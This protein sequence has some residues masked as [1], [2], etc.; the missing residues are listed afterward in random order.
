MTFARHWF[1][2]LDA[3]P[4]SLALRESIYGFPILLTVH[5][6]GLAVFSGLI[7]M[8]DLRLAGFGNLGSAVTQIQKRLFTWQMGALVVTSITG[9]LLLYSQPMRYYGKVLF[10]VKMGLMAFAGLNALVFHLT[11]Y[12][13]VNEWDNAAR[14]PFGARLAGVMSLILWAGVIIFGRLTAYE[15][16][17]YE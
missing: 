17:T 10:W 6:I 2:W 8:M 15:W 9:L 16:L 11:T 5:L 7:V 3:F 1:E 4:S 14:G 12:R 13:S